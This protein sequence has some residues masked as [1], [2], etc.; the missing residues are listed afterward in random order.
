MMHVNKKKPSKITGTRS[1]RNVKA[2]ESY[3]PTPVAEKQTKKLEHA[4]PVTEMVT[5]MTTEEESTPKGTRKKKESNP[6]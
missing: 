4:S 6:E 1:D 3:I 2:D 5:E